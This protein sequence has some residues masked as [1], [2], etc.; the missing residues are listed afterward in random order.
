MKRNMS[1]ISIEE[2]QTDFRAPHSITVF[3]Q[4]HSGQEDRFIEIGL[5]DRRRLLA[6]VYTE[7]EARIRMSPQQQIIRETPT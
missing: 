7:R 3:G 1:G 2:A 5:S 6:V 4:T